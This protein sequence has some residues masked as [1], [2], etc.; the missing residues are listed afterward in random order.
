[1]CANQWAVF[2][3][4]LLLEDKTQKAWRKL[5]LREIQA[6]LRQLF[7]KWGLPKGIQTDRENVYG[8]LPTEAFPT[9][10]TLWLA[11]LGIQHIIVPHSSAN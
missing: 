11:G 4:A 2:V 3:W 5:D 9:L 6:D 8:S 10:F 7:T 1:M